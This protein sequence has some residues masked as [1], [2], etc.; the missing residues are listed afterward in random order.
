M[1]EG[2]HRADAAPAVHAV[3]RVAVQAAA[4]AGAQFALNVVRQVLL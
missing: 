4:G 2:T 3:P 1:H